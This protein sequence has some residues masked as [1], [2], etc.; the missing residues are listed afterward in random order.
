M[1]NS[2]NVSSLVESFTY[3]KGF[4]DGLRRDRQDSE[5][6]LTSSRKILFSTMSACN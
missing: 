6:L 3:N 4:I 1:V 5:K 2:L